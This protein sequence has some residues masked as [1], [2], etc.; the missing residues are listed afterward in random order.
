MNVTLTPDME[1]W[2]Q[3][4]VRSGSYNSTNEVVEN[5]L[6]LL[7]VYDEQR[8]RRIQSLRSEL[9]LG[10]EQLNQGISRSFDQKLVDEIKQHPKRFG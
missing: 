7:H 9:L 1:N 3:E 10:I 6:R 8:S 4:K 5:A 2:I